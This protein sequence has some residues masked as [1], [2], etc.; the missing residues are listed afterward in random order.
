MTISRACAGLAFLGALG[1]GNLAFG[2]GEPESGA[3][4][5]IHVD[6]SNYEFTPSTLQL[7]AN[8]PYRLKLRNT[9]HGGHSFSARQLFAV[10]NV[11]PADRSKIEDGEVEVDGGQTVDVSFSIPTPG[12]YRFHCTHFLHS[13]FGMTGEAVVR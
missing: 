6:M 5:T 3:P 9:S 1:V 8:S 7:R 11:A 12:T 13:A 2:A 10:A 4:Q